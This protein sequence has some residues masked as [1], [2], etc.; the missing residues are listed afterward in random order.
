MSSRLPVYFISHG[1]GPWS[2]MDEAAR[3]PYAKLAAALADMP[4]QIGTTPRAVLMISAH[5]EEA[6]FTLT[7]N[8]K[9]P[10]IYDYG[11]FPDYT[12]QI[13][14]RAPGDPL[15]AA[16]TRQMIEKAGIP[17]RLDPDRGFDHGAFTPLKVIYPDANVPVVQLSLKRGLDPETHLALGR[18][19]A[20]LRDEGVLIV[21]S[22]LTYHNLRQFGRAQG[23]G[24]SREFDGWLSGVLLGGSPK[25][26]NKLLAAWEAAPAARAAHPREEHLLPLMVAS[27]AAGDDMAELTYHEK[28]F[29]GGHTVSSYRFLNS[30]L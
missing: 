11:G 1:G 17:A 27:G 4:R 3:A 19:I 22:G 30:P 10:M 26:R 20:P 15:L 16:H 25:D 14:Y 5:W 8:P 18:A 2:Y 23:W 7:A 24:P 9:P 28:D 29:M 21:G 6:E 13:H 12:Y